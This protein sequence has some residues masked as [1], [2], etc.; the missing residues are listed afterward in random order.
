[1]G[2]AK[3]STGRN[4][5]LAI[6]GNVKLGLELAGAER[7]ESLRRGGDGRVAAFDGGYL[8]AGCLPG[9]PLTLGGKN[10]TLSVR[11]RDSAETWLTPLFGK[12]ASADEYANILYARDGSLHYLWQTEPTERRAAGKQHIGKAKD[13][14][15][16]VLRLHVPVD[17]IGPNAWHNVL[18]RFRGANLELFVDGVL[19]DEEWPH[20]ELFGFRGPFLIGAGYE[21]GRL[22]AGFHGQIDHVALW[23]RAS[24]TKKSSRWPAEQKKSPTANTRST[25]RRRPRPSTGSRGATMPGLATACPSSTTAHF[26][27]F[28]SSI[29]TTTLAN[30]ARAPISMPIWPPKT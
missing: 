21:N 1:M 25:A 8:R 6:E 30:G 4:G 14:A 24:R 19:V 9:R 5:P 12:E 15:D 27:C 20:G 22:K 2:D 11:L 16:G 10:T 7:E 3:D 28:I 13:C 17:L 26:T 29:A 23:N 18:V